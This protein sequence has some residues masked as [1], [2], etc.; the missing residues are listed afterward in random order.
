MGRRNLRAVA[1][2]PPGLGSRGGAAASGVRA[3]ARNQVSL[4]VTLLDGGFSE[5]SW[6]AL[7]PVGDRGSLGFSLSYRNS[8]DGGAKGDD[9]K[10]CGKLELHVAGFIEGSM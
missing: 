2:V 3:G 10:K 8:K 4:C 5:G 6:A 9:S 7:L 1:A